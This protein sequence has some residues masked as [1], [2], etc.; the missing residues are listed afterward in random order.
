MTT[1][2]GIYG[3]VTKVE[4]WRI[5]SILQIIAQAKAHIDFLE[6]RKEN[7]GI[8]RG[9]YAKKSESQRTR[10]FNPVFLTTEYL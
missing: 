8:K 4:S 7:Q 10:A 1:A 6:N 5:G 3:V 9:L 2:S